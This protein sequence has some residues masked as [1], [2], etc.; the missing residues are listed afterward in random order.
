MPAVDRE[1]RLRTWTVRLLI[2]ELDEVDKLHSFMRRRRYET[3]A[4]DYATG[5]KRDL[6][7]HRGDNN[8]RRAAVPDAEP[9]TNVKPDAESDTKSD[10]KPHAESDAKSDAEPDGNSDAEPDVES[11]AKPD[12]CTDQLHC[13]GLGGLGGLQRGVW[14]RIPEA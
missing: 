12:V 10:A 7:C 1:E 2:H 8:L 4:G 14:G 5:R 9:S 13:F 3:H 11:H 6:R